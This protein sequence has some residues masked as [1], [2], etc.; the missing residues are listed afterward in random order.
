MEFVYIKR[1]VPYISRFCTNNGDDRPSCSWSQLLANH[2]VPHRVILHKRQTATSNFNR[3]IHKIYRVRP[4]SL[5][6]I[7]PS[8]TSHIMVRDLLHEETITTND[9]PLCGRDFRDSYVGGSSAA[10][11][12]F[13][14]LKHLLNL[15]F[16]W[17]LRNDDRQNT[18]K[19]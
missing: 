14:R 3:L 6:H 13:S 11:C 7:A 15:I 12:I 17:L 9:L 4:K 8:N 19:Y 10:P 1:K 5:P 18:R 16:L 2:V